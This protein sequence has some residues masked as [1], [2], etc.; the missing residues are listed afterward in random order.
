[1]VRAHSRACALSGHTGEQTAQL[2]GGRQLAMVLDAARIAAAS[3]SVTTN[4]SG[5][6]ERR[7]NRQAPR[8]IV[9]AYLPAAID[10]S[11]VRTP[12]L[13]DKI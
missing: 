7:H 6:W 10:K 1:M 9:V 8:F 4:I 12:N 5:V 11:V 3:A 2:H 13:V